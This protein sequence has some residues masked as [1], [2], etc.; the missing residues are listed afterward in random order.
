MAA[1]IA[2]VVFPGPPLRFTTATVIIELSAISE[3]PSKR[4][5][6]NPQIGQAEKPYVSKPVN[7][8]IRYPHYPLKRVSEK[9]LTLVTDTQGKR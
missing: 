1:R 9:Q 8:L 4:K 6:G 7:Q 3:F 5:S 2:T